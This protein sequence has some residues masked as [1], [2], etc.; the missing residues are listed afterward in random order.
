MGSL[1]NRLLVM[2]NDSD[3]GT[4]NFHI[5][6]TL[7]SSFY[8]L[9]TMS[10]DDVAKL[11]MVS[12]STISK[13]IRG[14]GYEDYAEFKAAAPFRENKFGFD[15]NYNQNIAEFIEREGMERYIEILSTDICH[16][17]E[18]VDMAKI[19]ELVSDLI[20]YRKVASFGLL[21][22]E[23][24]A[25]DLQMKLAYNGKF[26]MTNLSDIKQEDYISQS[27][28]DT[29]IIIYSNSG[30]YMQ[31]Y[32]LSEFHEPK[33]FSRIRAKIVLI[34]A[35]QKMEHHPGVDLCISF[36]H[37]S[38]VQT[39]SVV[40]PLVNDMIVNRYRERTRGKKQAE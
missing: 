12:K 17:Q 40:Y 23:I 2:L 25:I 35:N 20:H 31:R 7:L 24:G 38:K 3:H 21:F 9:C 27:D 34:T 16:T 26:I 8:D 13:F 29:L 15:L 1:L 11:C 37:V 5:A 33:D 30:S 19:D 14:I 32:Q 10:I 39:H 18:T 28:E 4:T 36:G 6:M 22:S